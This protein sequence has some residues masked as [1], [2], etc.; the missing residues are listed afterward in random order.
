MCLGVTGNTRS[1]ALPEF[2]LHNNKHHSHNTATE[3][4]SFQENLLKN[5]SAI[6]K[7]RNVLKSV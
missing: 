3:L 1:E 2:V 7:N 5:L 6:S 4:L